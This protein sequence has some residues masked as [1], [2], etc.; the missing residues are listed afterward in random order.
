[1]PARATGLRPTI[2]QRARLGRWVVDYEIVQN[3]AGT[4]PALAV[5][6][7]EGPL[8]RRATII[9]GPTQPSG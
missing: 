3:D 5:N 8:I 1:M 4:T 7:V 2:E 9:R 6:E